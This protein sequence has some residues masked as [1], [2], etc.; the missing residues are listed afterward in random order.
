MSLQ[1][2]CWLEAQGATSA[3]RHKPRFL[4]MPVRSNHCQIRFECVSTHRRALDSKFNRIR[5]YQR[6]I[7]KSPSM[8]IHKSIAVVTLC[9]IV[10]Y[11]NKYIY[12]Y[13]YLYIYIYTYPKHEAAT[14]CHA[15]TGLKIH[16]V[17]SLPLA[18]HGA[19]T[20]STRVLWENGH[21]M[22]QRITKC[23]TQ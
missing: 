4:G 9:H 21:Q 7:Q 10:L 11:I 8:T 13:V 18:F 6:I 17:F 22:P 5:E 19:S 14:S 15:E 16:G 20:S 12:I 23:L 1:P 3:P 2:L